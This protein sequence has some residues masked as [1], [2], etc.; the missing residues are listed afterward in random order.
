MH[1]QSELLG[2]EEQA[3]DP[4]VISSEEEPISNAA[5]GVVPE[6]ESEGS[7]PPLKTQVEPPITTS[8][9]A[10]SAEDLRG[11][12]SRPCQETRKSIDLMFELG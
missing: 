12:M 6:T 4:V 11:L 1:E 2:P 5:L 9:H 7:S 3:F 10:K 8:P